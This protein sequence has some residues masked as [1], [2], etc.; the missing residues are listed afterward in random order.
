MK[1]KSFNGRT[2]SNTQEMAKFNRKLFLSTKTMVRKLHILENM[3]TQKMENFKL[4]QLMRLLLK[5]I[6][7]ELRLDVL[8]ILSIQKMEK[9]VL[10]LLRLEQT[11]K[12]LGMNESRD[13]ERKE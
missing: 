2:N 5:K 8:T 13:R 6:D 3:N 7:L 1:M 4:L 9:L 10:K 12:R 11:G